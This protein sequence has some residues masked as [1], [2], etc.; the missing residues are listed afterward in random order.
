HSFLKKIKLAFYPGIIHEDELFTFQLY[1]YAERIGL[2]AQSYF[3]RRVR[4]NST[5]TSKFSTLN[6]DGYYRVAMELKRLRSVETNSVLSSLIDMR[7][8][9]IVGGVF[10]NSRSLSYGNRLY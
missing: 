7:L 8:R 4:G 1:A 9:M 3:K 10:Y 5:M 6:I 2:I